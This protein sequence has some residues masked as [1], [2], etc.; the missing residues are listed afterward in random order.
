MLKY[1]T[2]VAIEMH[3]WI[4]EQR[5]VHRELISYR[6]SLGTILFPGRHCAFLQA[7]SHG[8]EER[9]Y[10]GKACTVLIAHH[11]S[12]HVNVL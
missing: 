8:E 9:A 4:Q 12:R 3:D 1:V 2:R 5:R 11:M 10:A 6:F 7:S